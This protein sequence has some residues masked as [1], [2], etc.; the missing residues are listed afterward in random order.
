M[1]RYWAFLCLCLPLTLIPLG[2]MAAKSLSPDS[3]QVE[4]SIG[5]AGPWKQGQKLALVR[6]SE[7][8]RQH[9]KAKNIVVWRTERSWGWEQPAQCQ[10]QPH[11]PPSNRGRPRNGRHSVLE[12]RQRRRHSPRCAWRWRLAS[13][14]ALRR[15][16]RPYLRNGKH[17]RPPRNESRREFASAVRR[18]G[19]NSALFRLLL[20]ATQ[21]TKLQPTLLVPF[22]A[23]RA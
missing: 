4:V 2:I 6:L 21:K 12:E 23:L 15:E 19:G 7:E 5:V 9:P 16:G 10:L 11:E 22:V 3:E 1:N 18:N 8:L 17:K 13:A 20:T 14:R